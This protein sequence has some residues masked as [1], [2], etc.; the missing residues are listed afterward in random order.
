LRLFGARVGKGVLIKPR[1]TI[2]FPWR[3]QL[4]DHVWIGEE[5]R[6]ETLAEIR[7]GSH[8]CVSQRAFLCTGNHDFRSRTFDLRT[9]PIE[10]GAGVWVAAGAIVAPGVKIGPGA[11]LGLG[12]VATS[13]LEADGIY[14]GNPAVRT[15]TRTPHS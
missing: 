6:L 10:V 12:S 15:G 7:I 1:V 9:E 3:L 13:D 5:V 4:G 11:V 14:G 2:T 8:A